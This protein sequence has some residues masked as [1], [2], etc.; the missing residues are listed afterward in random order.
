QKVRGANEKKKEADLKVEE[1]QKNLESA[2]AEAEKVS[3]ESAEKVAAAQSKIVDVEGK[4]KDAV[5]K[6]EEADRNI[7]ESMNNLVNLQKESQKKE[8]EAKARIAEIDRT[9]KEQIKAKLRYYIER[10]VIPPLKDEQIER[11]ANGESCGTH[12]EGRDDLGN[13]HPGDGLRFIG[14]GYMHVVGRH[15]YAA[16]SKYVGIDLI[17]N[18]EKASEPEIA[19][20]SLIWWMENNEMQKLFGV[21]NPDLDAARFKANGGYNG[22]ED[23]NNRYQIYLKFLSSE[24]LDLNIL[25]IL[26]VSDPEWIKVHIPAILKVM[27]EKNIT[28]T[29]YK[30]YILATADHEAGGGKYI[31]EYCEL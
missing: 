24:N 17:V 14:R 19:A 29:Q 18:P 23:V 12:Y 4:M 7:K 21:N 20:L 3:Q 27:K 2:K 1:A 9:I 6:K 25:S 22:L 26:E 13:T 5:Q 10:R 15:N 31:T 11:I 28:D 16:L 8:E 30:A